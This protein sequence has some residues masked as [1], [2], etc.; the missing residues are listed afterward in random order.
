MGAWLLLIALLLP[1]ILFA[2]WPGVVALTIVMT[3]SA[4]V[5]HKREG[6]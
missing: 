6:S 2:G 5:F 3:A 4:V 1:V